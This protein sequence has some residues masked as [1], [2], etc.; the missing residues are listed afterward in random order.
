MRKCL[1]CQNPADSREHVLPKWLHRCISSETGGKFPVQVGRFVEGQGNLDEK[2][3]VSLNFQAKIVCETCNNGW[4][5]AMEAEVD[6]ILR[7]LT[8]KEL[9][10]DFAIQV[11]LLRPYAVI[12]ARWMAKTAL[13]TSYALPGK[14]HLSNMLA[15]ETKQ[16]RAPQGTWAD[17]AQARVSGIA[18]ALTNKFPTYNGKKYVG[19]QTHNTQA[20]F[21][22][23]LQVN[24]LLLRIAMTPAAQVGYRSPGGLIPFRLFPATTKQLPVNFEYEHVND[25]LHSV[26]LNTWAGC[27]GE[28]PTGQP[29]LP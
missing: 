26:V 10:G 8:G 17:V 25:F 4:M 22:F 9:A 11:S 21:Q 12:L 27:P 3:F 24:H 14:M 7:P 18:V 5:A 28:V 20:C 19:V 6:R 29:P 13:T 1:F 2:R 23:C 15:E 16:G